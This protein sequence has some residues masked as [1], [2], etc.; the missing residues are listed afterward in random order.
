L[1]YKH[2]TIF[3][4][5]KE[6]L[7]RSSP[8]LQRALQLKLFHPRLKSPCWEQLPPEIRQQTVPLLA[9]L[10]REHALRAC[11]SHQVKE[12]RDE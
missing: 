12:A 1:C 2:S 11:A 8:S 9:R 7:M 5:V 10:L 4:H 3:F 6:V